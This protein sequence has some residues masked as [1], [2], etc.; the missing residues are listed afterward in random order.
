[1]LKKMKTDRVRKWRRIDN[2]IKRGAG[3]LL[4]G[5]GR[6]PPPPPPNDYC[7][8][9]IF[10]KTIERTIETIVYCFKNNIL[11]PPKCFSSRKPGRLPCLGTVHRGLCS[12]NSTVQNLQKPGHELVF[13]QSNDINH[14]CETPSLP[15]S[16]EVFLMVIFSNFE[17]EKLFQTEIL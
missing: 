11:F 14:Y 5:E 4:Q 8:A 2:F 10:Q 15:S 3:L 17:I 16:I 6:P 7:P 9:K 13:C 12:T 1:M